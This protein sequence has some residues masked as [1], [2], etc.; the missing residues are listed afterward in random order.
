ME[1]STYIS[2]EEF[3]THYNID[4]SLVHQLEEFELLSIEITDE[5]EVIRTTELPKLEKM[6]RLN[7]ELEINPQGL[8]AIHHLL[9]QITHLQE[10]VLSLRRRLNRFEN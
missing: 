6:V 4:V 9:E 3:C 5:K 1:Q 10:E 8:Q 7:Q 2:I